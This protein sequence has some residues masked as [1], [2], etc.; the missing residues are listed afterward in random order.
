MI[1]II[2]KSLYFVF[3]ETALS[4][5]LNNKKVY[6]KR[7]LSKYSY[8]RC[9]ICDIFFYIVP[10]SYSIKLK[11][12]LCESCIKRINNINTKNIVRYNSKIIAINV[13]GFWYAAKELFRFGS[14]V[15][16][17]NSMI[18]CK[19]CTNHICKKCYCNSYMT[20]YFYWKMIKSAFIAVRN[21]NLIKDIKNI[22]LYNIVFTNI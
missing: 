22:L 11:Y 20:I 9:S 16:F 12:A 6:D 19:I 15:S 3:G 17:P 1:C 4:Y 7:K 2:F 5:Y 14:P 21:F 10:T 13:N 8:R 18:D